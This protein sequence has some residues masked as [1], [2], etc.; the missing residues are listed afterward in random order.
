L[1]I[2]LTLSTVLIQPPARSTAPRHEHLHTAQP[3]VGSRTAKP[4]ITKCA[5]NVRPRR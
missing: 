3:T 1:R 2:L 4:R 5:T